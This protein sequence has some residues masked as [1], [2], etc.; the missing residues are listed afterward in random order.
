MI[1]WLWLCG[2][3]ILGHPVYQVFHKDLRYH[4]FC[5]SFITTISYLLVIFIAM[6]VIARV[7]TII[8]VYIGHPNMSRQQVDKN[9][10]QTCVQYRN[11]FRASFWMGPTDKT[12]FRSGATVMFPSRQRCRAH[13]LIINTC[14][15]KTT[16]PSPLFLSGTC[17]QKNWLKYVTSPIV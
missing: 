15:C 1:L 12:T 6:R 5:S 9:G 3:I 11:S 4:Q 13:P 14:H 7:M 8:Y 16:W 10:L 2:Q 17:K